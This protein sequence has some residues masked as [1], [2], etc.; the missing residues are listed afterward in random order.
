MAQ[1]IHLILQV[2]TDEPFHKSSGIINHYLQNSLIESGFAV[3]VFARRRSHEITIGERLLQLQQFSLLHQISLADQPDI[4]IYC[5][6]GISIDTPKKKD[7]HKNAVFLHGIRGYPGILIKNDALDLYICNSEYLK[8]VLISL[9]MFPDFRR[10]EVLDNHGRMRVCSVRLPIPILE[11][12]SGYPNEGADLPPAVTDLFQKGFMIGHSVQRDKPSPAALAALT[13]H[14][15]NESKARKLPGVKVIISN[16]ILPELTELFR[17]QYPE[18]ADNFFDFFYAV[19][20]LNNGALLTLF[21]NTDFG[22]C[23]NR[24]PESFGIY[25]LESIYVGCPIYSNGI[26]NNRHLLPAGHGMIIRE[27]FATATGS[28]DAFHPIA[29]EIL[30]DCLT[31]RRKAECSKGADYIKAHHN[32]SNFS[33]DIKTAVCHLQNDS[34]INSYPELNQ[35]VVQLGPLIRQWDPESGQVISDYASKT[36]LPEENDL[37]KSIIGKTPKQL[38][39]RSEKERLQLYPLFHEGLVTLV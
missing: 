21:Q 31:G 38:Q 22:I 4:S 32:K 29:V 6:Q 10:R 16:D 39:S 35:M 28:A 9:M 36:L 18:E 24:Y 15:H 1:H 5:G 12:P 37:L 20:L 13:M 30:E 25:P 3:S 7:N 11:Y 17:Q 2:D 8:S 33:E 23:Y 14:L 19:P 27:T 26:G 34:T